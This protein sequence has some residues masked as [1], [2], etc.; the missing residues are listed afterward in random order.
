MSESPQRKKAVYDT[1]VVL[2]AA[3]S[4]RG[5]SFSALQLLDEGRVI[6]I[7]SPQGRHEY[8]DVLTRPAIRRKN[9]FLTPERVQLLLDRMEARA[10]PV[11]VIR[12][13]CNIRAILKTS[14]S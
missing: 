4:N 5:P 8:E 11:T 14:R 7:L 2:Q 12:P 6:V 9:P 3:L 13:I 10:E 1:G